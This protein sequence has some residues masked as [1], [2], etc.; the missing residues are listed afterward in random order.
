[1][2]LYILSFLLF[3]PYL[4][5]VITNKTIL[6][7]PQEN[8]ITFF[9]DMHSIGTS[10]W[11]DLEIIQSKAISNKINS[12]S[13]SLSFTESS[14][15]REEKK[16]RQLLFDLF[17]LSQEE[18]DAL[19]HEDSLNNSL[20]ENLL[21]QPENQVKIFDPRRSISKLISYL[22]NTIYLFEAILDSD[23]EIDLTNHETVTKEILSLLEDT[24]IFHLLQSYSSK[25]SELKEIDSTHNEKFHAYLTK[26]T[27]NLDDVIKTSNPELI[28]TNLK[29]LLNNILKHYTQGAPCWSSQKSEELLEYTSLLYD[30]II[31]YTDTHIED[32]DLFDLDYT[33]TITTNKSNNIYAIAGAGHCENIIKELLKLGY[34]KEFTHDIEPTSIKLLAAEATIK[35]EDHDFE[36]EDFNMNTEILN[37][38]TEFGLT[39]LSPESL[40]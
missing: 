24:T 1:M 6:R 19:L 7:S 29:E 5:P 12:D 22:K 13:S 37:R 15:L 40:I 30:K 34:T 4:Y 21:E 11:K 20:F 2:K 8:T 14:N 31:A 16:L 35:K 17:N 9:H 27:D 38:L 39:P 26:I 33:Y 32:L 36:D 25:L 23:E 10:K 18:K 28:N 3:T